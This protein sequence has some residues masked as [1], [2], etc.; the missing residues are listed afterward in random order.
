MTFVIQTY[1]SEFL[2]TDCN[3][4]QEL[5]LPAADPTRPQDTREHLS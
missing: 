2:L 1:S 4:E 5:R 3:P